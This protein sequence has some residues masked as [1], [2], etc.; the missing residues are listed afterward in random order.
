MRWFAVICLSLLV[1]AGASCLGRSSFVKHR[2]LTGTCTGACDHYLSCKQ[3]Q[4]T[5]VVDDDYQAC[6]LECQDVFS[7]DDSLRAFE[8]LSCDD[9]VAYVE[10]PSGRMPGEPL[11]RASSASPP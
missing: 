5:R 4:G 10:G 7:S 3:Q 8:S 2:R 6:E 11:P 9:A 1:L